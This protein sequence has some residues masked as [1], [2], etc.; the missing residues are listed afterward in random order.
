MSSLYFLGI[1]VAISAVGLLVLS[2]RG[3]RVASWDSGIDDFQ[4]NLNALKPDD[5]DPVQWAIREV[6]DQRRASPGS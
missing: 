1:A 5:N 4:H 2:L 3:R 6:G